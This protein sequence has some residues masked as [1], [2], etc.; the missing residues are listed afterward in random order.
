MSG[1]AFSCGAGVSEGFLKG[2]CR[3]L[4]VDLYLVSV[5]A[6]AGNSGVLQLLKRA[7]VADF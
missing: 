4:G 2:I 1:G 5:E 6:K 3:E 7:E